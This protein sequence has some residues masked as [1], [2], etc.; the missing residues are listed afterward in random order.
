MS[1]KQSIQQF[2]YREAELI[3]EKRWD[4]WL[5]LFDENVEYW[6]PAWDGDHELTDDP[7]SQMSLMFYDARSGLEDRVFRLKTGK[8]AASTPMPR[9][10]HLVTNIRYAAEGENGYR[11]KA[12]W[13][14]HSF[15]KRELNT[16]CGTYEYVLRTNGDSFKIEK[17]KIV[18]VND[19]IPRVLDIYSI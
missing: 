1:I 17:K 3:D 2:L 13:T 19:L 12:N 7:R 5:E 11:V 18:V 8:S 4:E 9:T 15:R 6:V 14:A 10:C 16:F